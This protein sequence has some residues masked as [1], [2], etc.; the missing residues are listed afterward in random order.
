MSVCVREIVN[1]GRKQR[2]RER[3][4]G[5][6]RRKGER[7]TIGGGEKHQTNSCMLIK[8]ER[9]HTTCTYTSVHVQ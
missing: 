3:G 1:R 9:D 4:G 5:V 2:E 8:L 7:E 6:R